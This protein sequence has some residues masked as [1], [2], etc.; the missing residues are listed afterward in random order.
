MRRSRAEQLVLTPADGGAPIVVFADSREP[1][2]VATQDVFQVS[3]DGAYLAYAA[4]GDLHIRAADGS[5]RL[6]TDYSRFDHMRFSPD[7]AYLVA[8]IGDARGDH[9]ERV[10][11][12]DLAS[13]ATRELAT[14]TSVSSLEWMRDRVVVQAWDSKRQRE[15]LAALPLN[16]ERTIL[17][18]RPSSDISRF[19]AAAT[20]TRVVAFVSDATATHVLSI[21]AAAPAEP[22]ELGVVHDPVTNAAA[23]LDGARIAFTTSAALF[24]I[25]DSE[26][27]RAISERSYIQSLWFARDGRLGYASTSSATIIDSAGAHRFDSDGPVAMLRFDPQSSRA[28]VAT[29]THAWDIST[30]TPKRIATMPRGRVLL[31]VDQFAGG[32]VTW[33]TEAPR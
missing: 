21:D 3:P 7:S 29:P 9:P 20:G 18:E 33:T 12:F 5:E 30:A 15:V 26:P 28:L 13:G 23:T 27:P 10:V 4:Y 11:L 16:G 19:V 32:L 1:G 6:L 17:L 25:T 8:N 14:F 24:T 22:V 31:G 2:E